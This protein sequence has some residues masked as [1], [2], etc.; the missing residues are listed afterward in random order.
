LTPAG[1]GEALMKE[2]VGIFN[3][4]VWALAFGISVIEAVIENVKSAAIRIAIVLLFSFCIFI[5]LQFYL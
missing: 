2:Y 3:G 4:G 5:F 1:L